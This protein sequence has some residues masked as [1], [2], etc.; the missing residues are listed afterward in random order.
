MAYR[1]GIPGPIHHYHFF[2]FSSK[3]FYFLP[4]GAC[5]YSYY[6]SGSRIEVA[7]PGVFP[8]FCNLL[9][10]ILIAIVCT[11]KRERP[12][13]GGLTEFPSGQASNVKRTGQVYKKWIICGAA[14][15]FRR[16]LKLQQRSDLRAS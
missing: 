6:K 11:L 4:A 13:F 3:C 9:M 1:D 15:F 8:S 10:A 5:P 2:T 7:W 16:W 12:S 14:K